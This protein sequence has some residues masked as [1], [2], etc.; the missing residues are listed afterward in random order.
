MTT[1]DMCQRYLQALND[2]DLAGV[3]SLF[4]GDA[5]ISSPLYGIRSAEAFYTELFAD[6]ARS[7]T[8]MLH[9][10]ETSDNGSAVALHF[11]YDWTLSDGKLVTF[12]CVD[13]IDLTEDRQRFKRLKIIYDT[14]GLRADFHASKVP[15][16]P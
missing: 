11:E 16:T 5:E 10:F 15:N 3:L 2:G 8:R 14:A 7:Q 4:A 12:E 6:T 9:V 13:V 1:K